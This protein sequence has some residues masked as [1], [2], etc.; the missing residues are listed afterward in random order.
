MKIWIHQVWIKSL[1]LFL[2]F[3]KTEKFTGPN[4]VWL[5]L[6]LRIGAH[7]EDCQ[8]QEKILVETNL[9]CLRN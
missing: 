6:G 5:V 8:E 1:N 9:Y 4:K 2:V 3:K 7:R